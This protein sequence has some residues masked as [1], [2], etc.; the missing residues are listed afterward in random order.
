MN[1]RNESCQASFCWVCLGDWR[2]H[3][4]YKC[5]QYV[6]DEA[7]TSRDTSRAALEKYLFYYT[8]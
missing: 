1:C 7:K 4:N 3:A 8:R 6:E 2:D 5:N